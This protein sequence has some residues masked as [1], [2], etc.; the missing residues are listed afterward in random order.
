MNPHFE[1]A[2]LLFHQSR[3]DMAEEQ[4]RLALADDPDFAMA[5]GL[6]ALCM[7]QREEFKEATEEARQAVTLAPDLPFSFYVLANVW[8]ARNRLEDAEDAAKRAVELNPYDANLHQT[9]ANVYMAQRRWTAALEQADEGLRLDAE[10][11]G[12]ANLR[13]MALVKL[14]RKTEADKVI[15]DVLSRDPEDAF[16]H[17][18]QGWTALHQSD[19]RKALEHFREALRLDPTLEYA[20]YGMVEALK[21][22]Y[23]VYRLMLRWFLFM[24][25]LGMRLQW[26]IIIVLF[27]GTRFVRD[28][29]AAHPE[30][31]PVLWPIWGI[32]IGFGVMT[33]LADPLFN[34]MLRL[35]RYGKHILS[36]DQKHGATAVGLCLAAGLGVLAY[37]LIES[38]SIALLMALAFGL[39]MLVLA[40]LFRVPKGGPRYLMGAAALGLAGIAVYGF[41]QLYGSIHKPRAIEKAMIENAEAA[42]Q[43]FFPGIM[44]FTILVNVLGSV[45]QQK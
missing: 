34:L 10:H 33:W 19:P 20:Q 13:A 2:E 14:G 40:G 44:I 22:R 23:L 27:L 24:S 6:L 38:D 28:A 25:R 39:Y 35:N 7:L 12:C 18:N 8:L 11:I 1:R 42:F 4:L 32:L 29:A 41:W 30:M 3:Y 36:N 31:G 9:L 45:R 37:G 21:A 17:A 5:H 43:I 26:A 15:K 16:S